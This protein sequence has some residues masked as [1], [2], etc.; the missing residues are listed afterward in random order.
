[1]G[2][3]A[4]AALI[5]GALAIG[6]IGYFSFYEEISAYFR[7]GGSNPSTV[8]AQPSIQQAAPVP[9]V[10]RQCPGEHEVAEVGST[11]KVV[12]PRA[13][14]FVRW[15]V[16]YG[17]VELIG[18]DG[19]VIRTVGPEGGNFPEYFESVRAAGGPARFRYTRVTS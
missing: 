4:K 18:T 8:T 9:H 3:L 13:L 5:I 19:K 16:D 12:N 7:G 6:V 10:S 14:C 2:K 15:R 11:P 17:R 1:M